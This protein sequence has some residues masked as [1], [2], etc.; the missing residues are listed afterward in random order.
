MA[1]LKVLI[2]GKEQMINESKLQYFVE[3]L[4]ASLVAEVIQPKK[5]V[6]VK[7]VNKN[8]NKKSKK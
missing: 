5:V 4:G 3:V 7:K 2:N 8:N 6:E 1:M